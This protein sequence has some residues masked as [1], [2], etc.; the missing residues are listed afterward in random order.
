M[1]NRREVMP[2]IIIIIIIIIIITSFFLYKGKFY[3]QRSLKIFTKIIKSLKQS[4]N[5]FKCLIK[6]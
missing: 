4:K 6:I 3:S 1:V 2:M 5:T